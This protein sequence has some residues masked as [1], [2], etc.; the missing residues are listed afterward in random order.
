MKNKKYL[1]AGLVCFAASL[2]GFDGIV[3]TPRLHQLSV[4][5]VVFILHFIPF[6]FMSCFFGKEEIKNIK[7]L[8][9]KDIFYYFCI[10][11]FGGSLGTISIVKALFLV[12]FQHLTV[13]TLLQKTQPIF[14]LILARIIL[15]E[16]LSKNFFF[17]TFLAMIGGYIM[18]FEFALP[19]SSGSGN[20]LS[21]SLLALLAAFSF[22]SSTAFGKRILTNS[23]FRTA[24]YTRFLFTSIITFIITL[25]KGDLV[26]FTRVTSFQ[27]L[28]FITIMLTSGSMA[29]MIYYRGLR[30]ID[31][32]VATI[33]E[34]AF[35]ISSVVFDYIFNGR[36][37]TGQ[38]FIGAV[39][40]VFTI[41]TIGK[42]QK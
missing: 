16:K 20:I 5:F 14:A 40:L 39:I 34:L 9:K 31:A 30:Y 19:H 28:I 13:V 6:L 32:S 29:I 41:I 11:L 18:T 3:L 10:G 15:K 33:C 26:Y 7:K 27:W 8:P 37:L 42:S 36:L 22:G 21:A 38:Q 1:G 25:F 2:W 35:P 24:L 4:P 12:N 23:S 17:L